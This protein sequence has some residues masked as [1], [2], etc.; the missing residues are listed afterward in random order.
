MER[1]RHGGAFGEGEVGVEGHQEFERLPFRAFKK[2]K[3]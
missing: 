3:K 1:A 2:K